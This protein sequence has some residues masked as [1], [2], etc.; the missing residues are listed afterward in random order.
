MCAKDQDCPRWNFA[1]T[2]HETDSPLLEAPDDLPV[3]HQ[4]P[5]AVDRGVQVVQSL[6]EHFDSAFDTGAESGRFSY[7]DAF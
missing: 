7:K 2:L 6:I 5:I 3:V 1:E 4:L